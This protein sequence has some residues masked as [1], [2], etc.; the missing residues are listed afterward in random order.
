MGK[1][2]ALDLA[3][4]PQGSMKEVELEDETVLLIN[5]QSGIF[6]VNGICTHAQVHLSGGWVENGSTIC[7]PQHGGKFDIGTGKAVAFPAVS[8]LETYS[9][10]VENN[11]IFVEIE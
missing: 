3:D 8:S 6:A 10:S 1:I 7:C 2:K 11:E 4:L 5:Q 9:V